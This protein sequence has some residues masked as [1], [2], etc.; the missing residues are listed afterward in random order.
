MMKGRQ[1]NRAYFVKLLV[2]L[3]A[4]F[5]TQAPRSAAGSE[6]RQVGRNDSRIKIMGREEVEKTSLQKSWAS[7]SYTSIKNRYNYYYFKISFVCVCV[8][9][10]YWG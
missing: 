5:A 8:C 7:F 1:W 3:E 9:V 2:M 6:N 4:C 10:W